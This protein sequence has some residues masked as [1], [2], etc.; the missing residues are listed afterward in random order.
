MEWFLLKTM[1]E[2][3]NSEVF[4]FFVCRGEV[5]TKI[6]EMSVEEIHISYSVNLIVNEYYFKQY[7]NVNVITDG[8][9]HAVTQE[10]NFF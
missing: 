4:E 1:N 10:T 6:S 5:I 8:D 7:I 9:R 3:M 2:D